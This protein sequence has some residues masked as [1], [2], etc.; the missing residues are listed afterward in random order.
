MNPEALVVNKTTVPSLSRP[1]SLAQFAGTLLCAA[2]I[3]QGQDCLIVQ[4]PVDTHLAFQA[5]SFHRNV[6]TYKGNGVDPAW[7]WID[8]SAGGL[9]GGT[10]AEGGEAMRASMLGPWLWHD[11]QLTYLIQFRQPG[12]YR[13]YLRYSFFEVSNNANY[14]NEDSLVIPAST[15]EFNTKPTHDYFLTAYSNDPSN[16]FFE[17]LNMVWH[18]SGVDYTISPQDVGVTYAFRM[19]TR[20]G[21]LTFDRV[22][23]H[24]D[25][26]LSI[27]SGK[28]GSDTNGESKALDI[29]PD[30]IV[31]SSIGQALCA[32]ANTNSTGL[33]ASLTVMGSPTAS[34]DA[35]YLTASSLPPGQL[36]YF[37]VSSQFA[38]IPFPGGSQGN[39]CLGGKIGRFVKLLGTSDSNGQLAIDVDTTF[40]PTIRTGIS[41]GETWHFQCWFL[42]QNPNATSNF[43]DAVAVT[44]Q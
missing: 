38:F 3:S 8:G 18:N 9:P 2:S 4:N 44:F 12:T 32:P 10:E 6:G 25:P 29:L 31:L 37:L 17:G 21:G 40:L 26:N 42:D 20:E 24:P 14:G 5:E 19:D 13:L 30:S 11:G 34:L 43:T 22:M 16:G 27:D 36:G 41:P 15:L 35:I 1:C 23:L 39:L 7:E 33:P 28:D